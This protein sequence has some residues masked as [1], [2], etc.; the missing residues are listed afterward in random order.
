[1]ILIPVI[2][3][4][5]LV[6]SFLTVCV[7]RIPLN[8]VRYDSEG[9]EIH[10]E[11]E[12]Q[13]TEDEEA[14]RKKLSISYPPRSFCPSC[15]AQLKWWHNIPV[16]SWLILGGKC[17]FCKER[18]SVM[19][20][21]VEICTVLLFV[22][23][24][25]MFGLTPTGFAILVFCCALLVISFIDAKFYIIPNVISYPGTLIGIILAI[26]NQFTGIFKPPMTQSFGE[27]FLGIL[28]GA[29]FLLLISEGYFRL[30]KKE[31]L[32]LGDVKLL[33]MTGAFFGVKGSLY[34]I[35]VGSLA[36]SILGVLLILIAGR[37]MSQALPFGPYLALGTLLYIFVGEE[38]ILGTLQSLTGR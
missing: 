31:G 5:L 11:T 38:V 27:A 24:Y 9:N 1:M 3:L 8:R 35:F 10:P 28:V 32:G 37:K 4:G 21:A 19:Y 29:G 18:I 34:T 15:N 12:E 13:E 2:V 36:G 33:A 7:Y 25:K 26:V 23:C 30:R 17:A 16:I 22:L 14:P 20:P 6:G